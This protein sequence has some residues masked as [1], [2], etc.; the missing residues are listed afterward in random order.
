LALFVARTNRVEISGLG[1][2]EIPE[3]PAELLMEDDI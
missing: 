3:M 1:P 2:D